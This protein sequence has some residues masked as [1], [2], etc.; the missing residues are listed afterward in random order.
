MG[1]ERGELTPSPGESEEKSK[2]DRLNLKEGRSLDRSR[3]ARMQEQLVKKKSRDDVIDFKEEQPPP[4]DGKNLSTT[5]KSD[6]GG[7]M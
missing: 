2:E 5:Q 3:E 1:G 6:D 7:G 4:S